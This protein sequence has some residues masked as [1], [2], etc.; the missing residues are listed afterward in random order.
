MESSGPIEHFRT[1]KPQTCYVHKIGA[2]K[3]IQTT[4]LLIN[5]FLQMIFEWNQLQELC[6][7]VPNPVGSQQIFLKTIPNQNQFWRHLTLV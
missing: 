6:F 7:T 3:F 5:C 2:L 4:I 1:R